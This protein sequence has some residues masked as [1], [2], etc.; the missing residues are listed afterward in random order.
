MT[1]STYLIAELAI[2]MMVLLMKPRQ[3]QWRIFYSRRF[4]TTAM[5]LFLVW[6]ALDQIALAI[7]LWHFPQEG[8]FPVRIFGL[9]LEEY[10]IFLIHTVVCIVILG[11]I[12]E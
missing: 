3:V 7:G 2:A 1:K 9:P 4:I 12:K 5:G 11:V 8:T 10:G 6:L